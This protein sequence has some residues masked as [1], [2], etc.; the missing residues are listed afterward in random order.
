MEEVPSVREFAPQEWALYRAL[1]LQ[2]L[3]QSPDAFGSSLEAEGQCGD[4]EWQERLRAGVLSDCDLPVVA[5]LG[6]LPIGLAWGRIE[7]L[8]SETAHLY[9]MWVAPVGRRK[10]VGEMLLEHVISWA[11]TMKAR[12]ILLS[13]ARGNSAAAR[14]YSKAGFEPIDNIELLST[15][16]AS[17]MQT[18]KLDL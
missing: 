6:S 5:E 1:R 7:P 15:D 11:R 12:S 9:Q 14:L 4:S 17:Q 2:A 10:G 18:M 13:V 16:S 8:E 3:K